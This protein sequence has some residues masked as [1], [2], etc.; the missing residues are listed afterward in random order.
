LRYVAEQHV[1]GNS[2]PRLNV[3]VQQLAS[4]GSTEASA[5]RLA[6]FG[7]VGPKLQN[8]STSKPDEDVQTPVARLICRAATRATNA[9]AVRAAEIILTH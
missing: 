5:S 8:R 9:R 1:T 2:F 7:V 3:G 4:V 6:R